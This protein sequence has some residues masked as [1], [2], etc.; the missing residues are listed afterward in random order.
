MAKVIDFDIEFPIP[1]DNMV[2]KRGD[3]FERI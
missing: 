2:L 1:N 3:Y